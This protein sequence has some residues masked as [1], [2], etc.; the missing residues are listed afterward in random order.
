GWFTVIAI[1]L[2][3]VQNT[4]AGDVVLNSKDFCPAMIV[5]AGFIINIDQA[6]PFKLEAKTYRWALTK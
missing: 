4:F 2:N 5:Q 3:Y 6:G 1:S